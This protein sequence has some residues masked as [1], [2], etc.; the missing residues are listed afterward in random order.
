M[1]VLQ[2]TIFRCA[3]AFICLLFVSGCSMVRLGY[4]HV[5]TFAAWM[6]HDYFDL[7]WEQRDDFARRFARL[8]AWHRREQLDDYARFMTEIQVRTKRGLLAADVL[9]V[10]DG[11]KQRYVRI[12]ARG[13]A[14]AADLLATL[15]PAQIDTF[16]K[17]LDRNNRKFLSE[18]GSEDGEAARRKAAER[19]TLSLL[20]DWVGP[21]SDAQETQVAVMLKKMPLAD[22]LRYGER[23]RRQRELLALLEQRQGERKVFS[24]QVRDWLVYWD[25][26]RSPETMQAFD[27]AW[28]SYAQF[29]ASFDR[30]LTP[31]QRNH[32]LHHLQD[33]I[34]DFRQLSAQP[35]ESIR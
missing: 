4:S 8:H 28:N 27:A 26:G 12:A 32:L 29:Y 7:G 16:R 6:A 23:L 3:L 31:A 1:S 5:D 18:H 17:K 11:V 19:R 20:R 34:D 33:Y 10:A 15:T 9:W 21:L 25:A 22:Q 14:D 35:A 30:M 13:A 24:Q 2:R